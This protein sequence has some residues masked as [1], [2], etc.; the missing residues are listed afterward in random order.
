MQSIWYKSNPKS[1][2]ALKAKLY[3]P[4]NIIHSVAN[5]EVGYPI[6]ERPKWK[7]C[8]IEDHNNKLGLKFKII[9]ITTVK[10]S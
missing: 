1:D 7:P 10:P 4:I 6:I 3:E 2:R 9:Q 5:L 8:C